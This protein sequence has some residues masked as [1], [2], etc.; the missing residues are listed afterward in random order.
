MSSSSSY[1]VLTVNEWIGFIG[2]IV[3]M[4]MAVLD[5]QI[6]ASSLSEIQAGL[7]ATQDEISWIQT[8][9]LIAE[10][11]II[12]ISGWLTHIFS[13]R[14][15]F[16]VSCLGFTIMSVACALSWNLES[17]VIFRAFQ[18]LF[19]GSM[20]PT[21]F[22]TIY[23]L[24]P[25][26]Q[27][28][29][30]SVIV[31]VVVTVAPISGPVI[32]GYLT[33]YISWHYLFLLNIIPGIMVCI[34]TWFLVNVDSPNISLLKQMDVLGIVLIA[35]SLASLQFILEEGP[36][37]EWF[38]NK[39][40]IVFTVI[41]IITFILLIYRILTTPNSVISFKPFKN[42]NFCA[43]CIFSF[44]IGWG[45]YSVIFLIP[46]YLATVHNLN[47]LQ[48]GQYLMIT[49]IFQLLSAPVAGMLSKKMDLRLML[50]MGLVLFGTVCMINTNIT[51]ESGFMD[52]FWPQAIRGFSL[53][54][55]FLPITT[56]SLGTLAKS[57][58]KNA[59][60][61][62]N[63]MRNLGGAIG[64]ALNNTLLQN[65]QKKN[66][67]TL[68]SQV[69]ETSYEAQYTLSLLKQKFNSFN[70]FNPD[71]AALKQLYSLALLESFVMSINQVFFSIAGLFFISI[72]VMVCV[73]KVDPNN[74]A[75]ELSH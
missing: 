15:V 9:Y 61:L 18:G 75:T 10:V 3:G 28:P 35:I 59:S 22:S 21:V 46:I 42:S 70:Y 14:I 23:I 58:V 71:L 62:Y 54:F 16:F 32:G 65:W 45:L 47:S 37:K 13:T 39:L 68:R 55:C 57:E 12:P 67:L 8:S 29:M 74:Q 19:G 66:F 6:V 31:G 60:G 52:L 56:I 41:T 25:P 44:V 24:F 36:R 30:I 26:K 51:S 63:L 17:M 43:G 49:G 20:I 27:Q 5:I 53:M 7:S 40:I 2:L 4:F 73:K 38:D 64:L 48:I 1:R 33:E 72:L 34:S 50:I 11:I 69:T